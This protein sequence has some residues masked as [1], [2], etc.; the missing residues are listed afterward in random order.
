MTGIPDWHIAAS[1]PS[2]ASA[3]EPSWVHTGP[4]ILEV[5]DRVLDHELEAGA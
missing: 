1:G 4:G 5:L 2:E 3:G